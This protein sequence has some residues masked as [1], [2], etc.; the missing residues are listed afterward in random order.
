[1]TEAKIVEAMDVAIG[2]APNRGQTPGR[3]ALAPEKEG[4]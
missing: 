1:M 3:T 2:F 4:G